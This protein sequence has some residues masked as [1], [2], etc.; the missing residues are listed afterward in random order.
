M[1]FAVG[2]PRTQGGYNSIWEIMDRLTKCAYYLAMKTTYKESHLPQLFILEIVRLHGVP[3]SIVSDKD[4]NF[5]SRFWRD[6]Q[7]VIGSK[8]FEYV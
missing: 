5:T 8:L 7:Q 2:L 6:F 1:N 3:T 4:P